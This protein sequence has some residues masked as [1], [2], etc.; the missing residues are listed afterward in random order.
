MVADVDSETIRL[1]AD[2]TCGAISAQE[3][4]APNLH[5]G[6]EATCLCCERVTLGIIVDAADWPHASIM[7]DRQH[8][9]G[10]SFRNWHNRIITARHCPDF[11]ARNDD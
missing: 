11:E 8:F 6:H 2:E 5:D 7:C 1:V 10:V 4:P 9:R 3:D